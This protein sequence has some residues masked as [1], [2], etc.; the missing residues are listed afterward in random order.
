MPPVQT[1]ISLPAPDG[2]SRSSHDPN[3]LPELPLNPNK[4]SVPPMQKIILPITKPPATPIIKVNKKNLINRSKHPNQT[5]TPITHN[6]TKFNS[7]YK[8]M[9]ISQYNKCPRTDKKWY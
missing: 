7:I 4:T 9:L 5:K 1:K 6:L 3:L 2:R 8:S